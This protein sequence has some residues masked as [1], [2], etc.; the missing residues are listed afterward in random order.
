MTGASARVF[1]TARNRLRNPLGICSVVS[2]SVSRAR[3]DSFPVS[4]RSLPGLQQICPS[5]SISLRNIPVLRHGIPPPTSAFSSPKEVNPPLLIWRLGAQPF[6]ARDPEDR[7]LASS[8]KP[9]DH[10][11]DQSVPFIVSIGRYHSC[12]GLETPANTTTAD[13]YSHLKVALG[14]RC[15]L[16]CQSKFFIK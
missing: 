16:R 7:L 14:E 5:I 9:Y 1:L 13:I 15:H 3:G 11:P 10:N 12:Q 4:I 8:L 6:P 2:S